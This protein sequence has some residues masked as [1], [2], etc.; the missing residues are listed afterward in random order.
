M[1]FNTAK[2]TN[3]TAK[4]NCNLILFSLARIV[5]KEKGKDLQLR[6]H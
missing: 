5:V 2:N 3:K 1:V 6:L 4:L